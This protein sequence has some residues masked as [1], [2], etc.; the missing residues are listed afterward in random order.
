MDYFDAHAYL[1]DT[2]LS[3]A[4]AAPDRVAA[5]FAKSG[6]TG[7]ALISGLAASCDFIT[8]N[9]RLRQILNPAAG[10]YGYVTLNAGYP[11]ESQEEQRKHL[12]RREFVASVLFG[13]DDY[14][15][16]LSDSREILNAQ[17]RYTK[18]MAI[19]A[20]NAA[21]VH[22]AREIA[23]E[24]P[25]MKFVLLGMGGDSWHAAVAAAKQN[26]NIYLEISGSMD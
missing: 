26:L 3:S 14:P 4:M 20:P 13:H 9:A 16:T 11:D 22:A 24:F 8:G 17:R 7:A 2:A 25:S 21:A 18:P 6:I 10:L 19:H 15:V 1:A 5:T 12:G 23:A